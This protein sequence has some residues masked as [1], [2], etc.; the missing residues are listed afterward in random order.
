M[1]AASIPAWL[2]QQIWPQIHAMM[3]NDAYFKLMGRARELTG[4]STGQS[5]GSLKLDISLR[6]RLPSVGSATIGAMSSPFVARSSRPRPEA[7]RRPIKSMG[8]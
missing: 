5:Q 4:D 7:S 8:S 6:R 2:D 1:N 3:L